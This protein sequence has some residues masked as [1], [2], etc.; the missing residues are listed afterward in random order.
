LLEEEE[1]LKEIL[2]W[3]VGAIKVDERA[4]TEVL[5][6]FFMAE[7]GSKAKFKNGRAK[8]QQPGESL[9]GRTNAGRTA[10]EK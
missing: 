10:T 6:L 9:L 5:A 3:S 1:E 8:H 4:K 2:V 7:G